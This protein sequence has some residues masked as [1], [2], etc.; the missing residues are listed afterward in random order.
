MNKPWW[1]AALVA[2]TVVLAGCN[3]GGTDQNTMQLRVLNA[4]VDAEPL[5]VLVD[6]NAKFTAV[7]LGTTT[8][9]SQLD[10]GTRTIKVRSSTN[11]AILSEKSLALG[12]GTTSTMVMYG[13]RGALGTVLLTDS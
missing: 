13:K 7:A 6:D 11:A 8:S 5:D 2:A 4:V 12:S 3:K 10:S 9:T 1:A